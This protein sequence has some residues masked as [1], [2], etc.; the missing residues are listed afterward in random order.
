MKTA[1]PKPSEGEAKQL[2]DAAR[3]A[4][5]NEAAD[6]LLDR[7]MSRVEFYRELLAETRREQTRTE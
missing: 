3:N 5:S 1:T 2:T 4:F 7:A 6:D